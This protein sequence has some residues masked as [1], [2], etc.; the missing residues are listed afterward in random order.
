V[1]VVRGTVEAVAAGAVAAVVAGYSG[2]A[3]AKDD[4]QLEKIAGDQPSRTTGE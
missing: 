1:Q 4:G 2:A 3:D